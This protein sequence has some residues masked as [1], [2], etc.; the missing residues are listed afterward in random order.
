M[1]RNK[2]LKSKNFKILEKTWLRAEKEGETDPTREKPSL[3]I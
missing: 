3:V 2:K 1:G